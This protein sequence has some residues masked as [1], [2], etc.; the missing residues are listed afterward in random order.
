MNKTIPVLVMI[1]TLVLTNTRPVLA[2]NSP[3]KTEKKVTLTK[4]SFERCLRDEKKAK[5]LDACISSLEASEADIESMYNAI[6]VANQN[7]FTLRKERTELLE[8]VEKQES[9]L[10]GPGLWTGLGIGLG[11]GFV[12]GVLVF[13]IVQNR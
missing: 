6:Q 7:I 2:E 9:K 10:K 12:L 11:V 3:E 5:H 8:Q 1:L 4:A 13:G